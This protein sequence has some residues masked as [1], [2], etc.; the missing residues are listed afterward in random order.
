MGTI[1]CK[2]WVMIGAIGLTAMV[3]A[4]SQEQK[5]KP[6]LQTSTTSSTEGGSKSGAAVDPD[7]SAAADP[8]EY[9][10][11]EQDVL[12]ITVWKEP[13]LS[14]PVVVRPD[15]KISLPLV[16]E[17]QAS[18]LTP[19]ELQTRLTEKFRPL[20]AVPEIN[21]AVREVNSRK[22]Y[23]LGQVGKE[24]PYRVNSKSTVL[25]IIAEAGGLRDYANRKKMYVMRKVNGKQVRFPFN[26]DAVIKGQH[27]EENIVL[28][29]GDTIVAP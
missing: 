18:G 15:G 27:T 7:K 2:F 19:M 14:G 17:M 24:G 16:D 3:A 25:E 9:R 4:A 26:Y 29:P 12:M 6:K 10:I 8:T 23:V 11:G 5:E 22:V 20:L 21:V 13:Q 28:Q 1:N